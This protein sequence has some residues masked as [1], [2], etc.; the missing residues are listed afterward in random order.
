MP[1]CCTGMPKFSHLTMGILG[2]KS[3][4]G[5][6]HFI[7]WGGGKVVLVLLVLSHPCSQCPS[8]ILL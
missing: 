2:G 6:V 8:A 5:H 4:L 3:D 7:A 1:W